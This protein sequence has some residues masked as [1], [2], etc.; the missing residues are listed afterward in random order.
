MPELSVQIN[1]LI[2]AALRGG[3]SLDAAVAVLER[4]ADML[5]MSAPFVEA[6]RDGQRGST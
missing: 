4:H 1:H 6:V 2:I 3:R 5:R